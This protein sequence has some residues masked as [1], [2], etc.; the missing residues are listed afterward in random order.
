MKGWKIDVQ[1]GGEAFILD[2]ADYVVAS[3]EDPAVARALLAVARAAK[4]HADRNHYP[5]GAV[6]DRS[7]LN[8][9]SALA[10]LEKVSKPPEAKT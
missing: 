4:A 7:I 9:W 2:R 3:F 6:A 1:P 8:L 5:P 10:R